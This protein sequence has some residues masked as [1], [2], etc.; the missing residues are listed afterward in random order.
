MKISFYIMCKKNPSNKS[1]LLDGG[2]LKILPPELTDTLKIVLG[3]WYRW[4]DNSVP[5]LTG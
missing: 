4:T 2:T 5:L 3:G 1:T